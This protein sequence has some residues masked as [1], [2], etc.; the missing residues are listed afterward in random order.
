MTTHQQAR[1]FIHEGFFSVF[2]REPSLLEMQCCQAVAILETH[3]GDGWGTHDT[4]FGSNNWGAVQAGSSWQGETF[5]HKDSSP[6][7]DGTNHWYT[8]KFRRYPTEQDGA[9]DLVRAVYQWHGR[10][11]VLEA[12]GAGDIYGFS[13]EM[14]ASGYYEGFG[15]TVADRIANHHKAVIAAFHQFTTALGEPMPEDIIPKPVLEPAGLPTLMMGTS[16]QFVQI[17]QEKL[18]V[19]PDGQF[20]PLTRA[21]VVQFQKDHGLTPDG[22]VGKQTWGALS[23]DT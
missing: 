5:E 10:A 9:T 20:G 14:H 18:G 23:P 6:Q 8:T 12:A 16:G 13:V 4:G 7:A 2:G 3:Y 21:A 15:K 17:L 11:K 1:E 22:W 19:N